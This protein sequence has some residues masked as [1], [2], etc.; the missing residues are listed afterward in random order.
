MSQYRRFFVPGGTYFFTLV[1]AG[2]LYFKIPSLETFSAACCGE[3]R[4]AIPCK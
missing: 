4:L 2:H 1:T 3:Q